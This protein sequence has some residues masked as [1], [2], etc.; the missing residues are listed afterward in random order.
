[1]VCRDKPEVNTFKGINA[2]A[3]TCI[4]LVYFCYIVLV[5]KNLGTYHVT[6]KS[7]IKPDVLLLGWIAK[8]IESVD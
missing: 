2:V 7:L 8:H 5:S 4:N 1:M 6:F 3:N